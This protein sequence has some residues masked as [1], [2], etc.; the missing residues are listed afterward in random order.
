MVLVKIFD[1]NRKEGAIMLTNYWKDRGMLEYNY[2]WALGYLH[3]G[4]KKEVKADEFFLYKENHKLIGIISIITDVSNVA[5]IRDMVVK[6]EYR[7][8][9][10]ATKMLNEMIAIAKE[11]KIRKIFAFVFPEYRKMYSSAG[12]RKEG[13]LI[14]HFKP[15][16]DLIIM[17]KQL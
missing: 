15:G 9:G 3:E 1:I 11:R 4:H 10:Y 14:S 12:F 2:K 6:R 17:S 7:G 5:E 13:L 16:E 8:Q